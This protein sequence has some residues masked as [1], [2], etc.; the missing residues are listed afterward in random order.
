MAGGGG[1]GGVCGAA[2]AGNKGA[3]VPG[4]GSRSPPPAALGQPRAGPP[5]AGSGVRPRRSTHRCSTRRR[6]SPAGTWPSRARCRRWSRGAGTPWR[7]GA[8]GGSSRLYDGGG[9][10]RTTAIL[11][12]GPRSARRALRA[13]ASRPRPPLPRTDPPPAGLSEQP[14]LGTLRGGDARHLGPAGPLRPAPL[15][16]VE[17]CVAPCGA[18]PTHGVPC[19]M[20]HRSATATP[21]QE[22]IFLIP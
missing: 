20:R 14:P 22:G 8:A 6:A 17:R 3:A 12:P 7:R 9:A 15:L 10:P 11:G 16:R 5:R 4:R 18:A 19:P 2:A 1:G 21:R 13:A